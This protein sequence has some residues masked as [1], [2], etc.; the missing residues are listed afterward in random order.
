MAGEDDRMD[1]RGPLPGRYW[2]N[3]QGGLGVL[4]EDAEVAVYLDLVPDGADGGLA[5]AQHRTHRPL[6][7]SADALRIVAGEESEVRNADL[8]P[9]VRGPVPARTGALGLQRG[10]DGRGQPVDLRSE[11]SKRVVGVLVAVKSRLP[12]G[13]IASRE[14]KGYLPQSEGVEAGI[15]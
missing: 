1:L 15:P 4:D 11:S 9:W 6:V 12:R 14:L 10:A 2:K 5:L 7:D 3:G 8:Q 13:Q